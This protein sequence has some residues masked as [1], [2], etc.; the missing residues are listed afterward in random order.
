MKI[1]IRQFSLFFEM[2]GWNA[3]SSNLIIIEFASVVMAVSVGQKII[4][5]RLSISLSL[6]ISIIQSISLNRSGFFTLT[7][8]NLILGRF[9]LSNIWTDLSLPVHTQRFS[10]FCYQQFLQVL[11]MVYLIWQKRYINIWFCYITLVNQLI[12][13]I[14]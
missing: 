6:I 11:V 1:P 2:L 9:G 8:V 13:T 10:V 5:F 14:Y 4:V 12:A 7:T 3:C